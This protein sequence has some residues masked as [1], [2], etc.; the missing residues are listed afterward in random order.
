[1]KVLEERI[2]SCLVENCLCRVAKI[3]PGSSRQPCGST[4]PNPGTCIGAMSRVDIQR[5]PRPRRARSSRRIHGLAAARNR[6][7]VVSFQLSPWL[8]TNER[9]PDVVNASQDMAPTSS[10]MIRVW[11][12][13]EASGEAAKCHATVNRGPSREKTQ[14]D[15]VKMNFRLMLF[16]S[17]SSRI[18]SSNPYLLDGPSYSRLLFTTVRLDSSSR[19]ISRLK[20]FMY[21][22][23]RHDSLASSVCQCRMSLSGFWLALAGKFIVA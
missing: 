9:Q 14:G 18:F 2:W 16:V 15:D 3:S 8:I 4:F 6:C 23:M 5:P 11:K 7:A 1:M 22:T 10:T 20:T 13:S 21:T 12:R 19:R 17:C